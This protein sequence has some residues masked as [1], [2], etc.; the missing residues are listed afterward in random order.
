[1]ETVLTAVSNSFK[2]SFRLPRTRERAGK[3]KNFSYF[4]VTVRSDPSSDL[5]LL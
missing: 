2:V 4:E 1:M 3:I 5:L